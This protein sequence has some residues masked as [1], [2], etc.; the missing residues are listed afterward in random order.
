[1]D[2]I[3]PNYSYPYALSYAN[4]PKFNFSYS[5]CASNPPYNSLPLINPISIKLKGK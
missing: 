3:D 5:E 4:R 1:M 2:I